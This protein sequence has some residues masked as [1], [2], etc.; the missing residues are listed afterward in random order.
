[1]KKSPL[2][3]LS[4]ILI[5]IVQCAKPPIE[6][7]FMSNLSGRKSQLGINARAGLSLAIEQINKE[8]GINGHPIV[9]VIK[10]HAGDKQRAEQQVKE[11]VQNN[12]PLIIGPFLSTMVPAIL[13]N[14]E[15]ASTIV[16]SPTVSSDKYSGIDDHF[17]RVNTSAIYQSKWI[18]KDILRKKLK[19]IVIVVDSTNPEYVS[20]IIKGATETLT[21]HN[22]TINIVGI[23]SKD[24]LRLYANQAQHFQPDGIIFASSGIDA[25]GVA[26]Q[27]FKTNYK[28]Q[29][30]GTMWT[31]ISKV[32][33]YGGKSVEKMILVDSYKTT[34]PSEAEHLFNKR[35][36]DRF[37]MEPSFAARFAYEVMYIY[38][39][40][41]TESR[42][43]KSIAIKKSLTSIKNFQGLTDS[44]SI[45]K[46]GDVNRKFSLYQ[47]INNHYV[48]ISEVN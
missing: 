41:A 1:M 36:K 28:A 45:D 42:T 9:L 12:I 29:L 39:I 6:I 33:L 47:I 4:L 10:D 15:K 7:G 46:Y 2:L 19:S 32:E 18:S 43:F 14:T 31:K 44:Y 11:L 5:S 37:D 48:H 26:Q 38:S 21:P 40:A 23:H 13:K 25:A 27:L 35:F 30:Y 17:F 20:S 24:S 3:I 34:I 22:V 8:G 16:F